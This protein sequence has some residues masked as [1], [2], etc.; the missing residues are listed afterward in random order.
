M[1]NQSP[2]KMGFLLLGSFILAYL[3]AEYVHELCHFGAA[4]ISGGN[5]SGIVIDPFGWS[6]SFSNS[7]EHPVF[8]TAA[9]A[10][11]SSLIG[12]LLFVLLIR[13][14]RPV[15]LPLL[16]FGPIALINNGQYW[17]VDIIEGT[18]YDACR[19]VEMGVPISLIL[20]A[21]IAQCLIGIILMVK[22]MR[23]IGVANESFRRRMII[24][25]LGVFP[26]AIAGLIWNWRNEVDFLWLSTIVWVFLFAGIAG[27]FR[28]SEPKPFETKWP[29]VI[30]FNVVGIGLIVGLLMMISFPK[31]SAA[32]YPIETFTTRP[33]C[34]PDVLV[35]H[36]LA[37][38]PFYNIMSRDSN[39]LYVLGYALPQEALPEQVRADL[40]ALFKQHG[41]VRL[42]YSLDDPNEP[43]DDRWEEENFQRGMKS[44]CMKSYKQFWIRLLPEV[45]SVIVGVCYVGKKG[46]FDDNS[47]LVSAWTISNIDRVLHYADIHP[48]AFNLIDL[49][50]LRMQAVFKP[51]RL[52]PSIMTEN[53]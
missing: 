39:P 5:A 15:L 51:N 25:G 6:Y 52:P 21:G 47:V 49:D 12:V 20:A 26:Y 17:A 32:S 22:L 23:I 16:L 34:F 8:H 9:G 45:S 24:L 29:T 31:S 3:G 28:I 42:A 14:P 40:D 43:R 36:P 53:D 41:Y 44:L 48:D 19:L 11:G 7:I 33:E 10:I 50:W 1:N 35:C 2:V 30:A 27:F 46:A 18:G 13:W 4:L 37:K 38:E